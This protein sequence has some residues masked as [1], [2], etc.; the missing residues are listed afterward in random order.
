MRLYWK[1]Q[2]WRQGQ[3]IPA[4]R[5]LDQKR[6]VLTGNPNKD[7]LARERAEESLI[8]RMH[9]TAVFQIP[10]D[11]IDSIFTKNSSPQGI[12]KICN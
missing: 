7:A 9:L 8:K 6:I 1:D 12:V 4:K 5:L 3:I 10:G 11:S 2:I